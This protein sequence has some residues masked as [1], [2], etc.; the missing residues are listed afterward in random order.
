M[1]GDEPEAGAGLFRRI[2]EH[3]KRRP[4]RHLGAK[5]TLS[6]TR[7][8]RSSLGLILDLAE[9]ARND[10]ILVREEVEASAVNV[11]MHLGDD[12]GEKVSV[13]AVRRC[14]KLTHAECGLPGS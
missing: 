2:V 12:C 7:S 3:V 8:C 10:L 14:E 11:L 6:A 9:Q 13:Q 1:G 4:S 5:W